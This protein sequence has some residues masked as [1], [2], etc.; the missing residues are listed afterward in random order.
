MASHLAQ[1]NIARLLYPLNDP[2]IR[3]FVDGL[4]YINQLAE[5]SPGFVWRLKPASGNAT[6]ID[7]PWCKD[8]LM[9]ANF[10]VWES[11]EHLKDYLYRSGHLDYYLR[12]AEWFD[13]PREASAVLWW[14]PVGAIPGLDEA[15]AR[16]EHYRLHGA[17]AHA[18]WYGKLYPAP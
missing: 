6:V 11:P 15:Q 1:L 3:E 10:S 13:K 2:R 16:L 5:E 8:P 4:G 12:R 14:I 17:S 18:F 7:H 9:L